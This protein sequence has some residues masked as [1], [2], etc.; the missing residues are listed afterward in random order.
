MW[1]DKK[2]GIALGIV[3]SGSSI[4]DVI[5]PILI[6][7]LLDEVGFPWT[8][9][10]V[11]FICLGMMVISTALIVERHENGP[12]PAPVD[13]ESLKK[14]LKNP[15]YLM[16]T[17]GFTFGFLGMFIPFFYLPLYGIAHGMEPTMANNLLAILNG[18][19]FFGRIISGYLADNVGVLV[20]SALSLCEFHILLLQQ[21]MQ[22][23]RF[24][25]TVATSLL[26]SITLLSLLSIVTEPSIIAFSVLYGLFS[27]GLI[28]LQALSVARLTVNMDTYGT[29]LGVQMAINSIG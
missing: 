29:K 15:T 20:F 27:G 2:R 8:L 23:C 24:N 3:V 5:W 22:H 12:D 9:R 11:G 4:G 10:I 17:A 16:V 7:Y 6:K 28:S 21:L 14:E 19:S 13:K 1:F 18:G 25:I 26:S